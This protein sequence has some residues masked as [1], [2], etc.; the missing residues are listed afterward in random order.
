MCC[1]LFLSNIS[2]KRPGFELQARAG[3]QRSLPF[4][5]AA[6]ATVRRRQTMHLFLSSHPSNLNAGKAHA[7]NL[8]A[9]SCG[10]VRALQ[11]RERVASII[12]S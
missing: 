5:T 4:V 9:R 1:C 6:L 11:E 8:R 2:L 3:K 7:Q 10:T 12:I